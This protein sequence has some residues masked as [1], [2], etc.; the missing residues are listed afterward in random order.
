MASNLDGYWTSTQYNHSLKEIEMTY[1]VYVGTYAKYSVG[2]MRGKW[3]DL[4]DYADKEEFINACYELHK[5]EQ[6]PELMF[7][8][9][10]GVQG[11]SSVSALLMGIC[12]TT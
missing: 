8:D 6:A 5:D 1:R 10:E 11:H 12:G 7:Q 9:H 4:E 2:S 3:L